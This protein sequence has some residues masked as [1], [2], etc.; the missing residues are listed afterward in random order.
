MENKD[1]ISVMSCVFNVVIKQTVYRLFCVHCTITVVYVHCTVTVVYVHCTITVV[2]VHCTVTVVYV[3]EA[4]FE[5]SS[6]LC[7]PL[8]RTSWEPSLG[9]K[10]NFL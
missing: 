10:Q 6:C 7:L 9:W 2:Y 3:H 4:E 1:D 5:F 8:F